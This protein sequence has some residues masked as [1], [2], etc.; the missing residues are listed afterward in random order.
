MTAATA[1]PESRIRDVGRLIYVIGASGVGKDT[2]LRHV[3]RRTLPDSPWVVAHRYI[4]RAPDAG[5]E[6]HI[7]LSESEFEQRRTAGLFALHWDSH[8]YRYGIGIEIEAWLARGLDVLVNGSRGYLFAA[9][10][11]FPELLPVKIT[12]SDSVLRTRLARRGRESG[13]EIDARLV[14][15]D[16][17]DAVRCPNLYEI[18]NDGRVEIAGDALLALCGANDS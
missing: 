11:R 17:L 13:T 4:T 18:N 16:R 1:A 8:G 10:K 14:R 6:N 12:V 9:Q 3:R 5:P 15:A 2:V 7:T